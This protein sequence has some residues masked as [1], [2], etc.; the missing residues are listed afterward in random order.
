MRPLRRLL[1]V[2][3][4]LLLG[5][6][7]SSAPEP[8]KTPVGSLT[9]RLKQEGDSLAARGEYEAAAVKYQAAVNQE[10]GDLSLRFAL[11]TALSHLG[12]RQETIE[13]FR[14]VAARGDPN[15]PEFQAAVKWL[16]SAGEMAERVASSPASSARAPSGPVGK[17][18]GR[19]AWQRADLKEETRIV[20]VDLVGDEAAT[21]SLKFHLDSKLG[22]PYELDNVPPGKYRLMAQVSGELV[23][24]QKVTIGPGEEV[25]LDLTTSNSLFPSG[26]LPAEDPE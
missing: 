15:S 14:W 11:G 24:Q 22:E 3:I 17:V 25:V 8:P 4:A 6:Q 10:P 18:K 12:R 16:V 21:R 20:L 1:L 23:W 2:A 7:Q 9:L 19:I 5:C 26:T 13:Q